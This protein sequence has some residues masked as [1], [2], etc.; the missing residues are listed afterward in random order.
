MELVRLR[1]GFKSLH[2]SRAVF[3][4]Q[5]G[6]FWPLDSITG[7]QTALQP[8]VLQRGLGRQPAPSLHTCIPTFIAH[9]GANT[10]IPCVWLLHAAQTW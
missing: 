10:D 2:L 7:V 4:I 9:G 5:A 3:E 8:P 1:S 6:C